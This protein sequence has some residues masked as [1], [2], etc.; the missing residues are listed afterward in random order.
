LECKFNSGMFVEMLKV[1]FIAQA[2]SK[3]ECLR[4]IIREKLIR[5]IEG[6]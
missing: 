6:K 2:M 4:L 3:E 5:K 1:K